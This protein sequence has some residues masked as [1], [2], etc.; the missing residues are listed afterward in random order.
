[1]LVFGSQI[2]SFFEPFRS[3]F[4]NSEKEH[5]KFV[6]SIFQ[7]HALEI[8]NFKN[9]M[10]SLEIKLQT[11][12]QEMRLDQTRKRAKDKHELQQLITSANQERDRANLKMSGVENEKK[13]LENFVKDLENDLEEKSATITKLSERIAHYEIVIEENKSISKDYAQ[14]IEKQFKVWI[15]F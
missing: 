1:L 5:K 3:I 7:K 13:N 9:S 8:E 11:Q 2:L 6:D 10:K 14:Q 4:K 12:K 15:I